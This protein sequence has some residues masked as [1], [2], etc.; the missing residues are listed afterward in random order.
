MHSYAKA[1]D[2]EIVAN[3]QILTS[4]QYWLRSFSGQIFLN[5]QTNAVSTYMFN[6]NDQK[7]KKKDQRC[8]LFYVDVNPK[9][10]KTK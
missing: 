7:Q 8:V 9:M 3:G 10:N 6:V 4:I 2:R 5:L 1:K